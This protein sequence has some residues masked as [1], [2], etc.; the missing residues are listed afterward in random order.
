[1]AQAVNYNERSEL[2]ILNNRIRRNREL[3]RHIFVLFISLVL[4]I[5]MSLLFFSLKANA[6]GESEKVYKYYLT[7]EI[8]AGDTITSLSEEYG[9]EG[10]SLKD[11]TKEVKYINNLDDD[12]TLKAG[13]YIVVPCFLKTAS[14]D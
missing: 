7:V 2:R 9:K 1:M 4:M 11:F 10:Y 8:K 3:R 6:S 14:E 12:E 13:S 5:T